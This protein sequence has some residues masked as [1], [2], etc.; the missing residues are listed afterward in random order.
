MF[1]YLL[2]LETMF[3]T[4]LEKR[5]VMLNV[6]SLCLSSYCH[7]QNVLKRRCYFF[8]SS[9]KNP[10]RLRRV[11]RCQFAWARSKAGRRWRSTS[12]VCLL[13]SFSVC[14]HIVSLFAVL[15]L[16]RG[17]GIQNVTPSQNQQFR[18]SF[19]RWG[20]NIHLN[21]PAILNKIGCGIF[22]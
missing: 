7:T 10:W 18:E 6:L 13:S 19:L 16:P 9:D 22:L 20:L 14:A 3:G 5:K 1:N 8:I 4:L 11:K 12:I 15:P 21:N 17:P 2:T